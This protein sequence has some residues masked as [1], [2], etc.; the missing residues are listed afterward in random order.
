MEVASYICDGIVYTVKLIGDEGQ[1]PKDIEKVLH[2]IDDTDPLVYANNMI[3]SVHQGLAYELYKENDRMG[4]VYNRIEDGNYYGASI[5]ID[6]T[7]CMLIALKTM[8]E[9]YETHKISFMP[10]TTN[11]QCFKAMAYGPDIRM[12][13]SAGNPLIIRRDE[14][15]QKGLKL[16]RYFGIEA[17]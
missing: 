11:L 4:F 6:D 14:L 1:V 7:I 5:C 10:H 3:E 2:L 12:H 17:L 13:Y 9:L 15:E 8:F 16:F